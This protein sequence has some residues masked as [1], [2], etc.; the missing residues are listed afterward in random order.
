ML[1]E[2]VPDVDQRLLAVGRQAAADRSAWDALLDRVAGLDLVREPGGVSVA[3]TP[4]KGYD[5]VVLRAFW[6]P[7]VAGQE[8]R[9]DR[10]GRP[11]SSGY[12]WEGGAGRSRSWARGA[13]PSS[14]SAAFA[15][16]GVLRIL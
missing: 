2:R 13:R 4:L 11:E 5:S 10:P 6:A 12:S 8:S 7:W 16:F 1:K 3:A 9:S 14:R 15:S